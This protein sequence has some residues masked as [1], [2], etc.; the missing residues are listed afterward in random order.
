MTEKT[1]RRW[2]PTRPWFDFVRLLRGF[3]LSPAK[4]PLC[5]RTRALRKTHLRARVSCKYVGL[6]HVG[7][8]VCLC[9]EGGIERDPH[10]LLRGRCALSRT[11]WPSLD[12]PLP[13]L[14]TPYAASCDR[15]SRP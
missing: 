2:R 10:P 3:L 7:G 15:A 1:A 5:V 12:H 14:R 6:H 13:H 9:R 11:N 4:Q 8:S